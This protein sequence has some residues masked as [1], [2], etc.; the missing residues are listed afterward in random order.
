M[1]K[2]EEA[3]KSFDKSIEFNSKRTSSYF[4]K[5]NLLKE[6]QQFEAAVKFYDIVLDKDPKDF[7]VHLF[8]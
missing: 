3:L 7:V 4:H 5:A 8:I 1:K 2:F 6:L